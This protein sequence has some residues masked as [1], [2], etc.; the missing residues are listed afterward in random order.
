MICIS[1]TQR[2]TS[3]KMVRGRTVA[4]HEAHWE[5]EGK[6]VEQD[7]QRDLH[8]PAAMLQVLVALVALVFDAHHSQ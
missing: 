5:E 7:P 1:S 2:N 4:I 8:K 6:N 3:C